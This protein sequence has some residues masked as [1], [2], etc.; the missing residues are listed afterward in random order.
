MGCPPRPCL[1]I[2]EPTEIQIVP[3]IYFAFGSDQ[4]RPESAPILDDIARAL[5][6]HPELRVEII[7][8]RDETEAPALALARAEVVREAFEKRGIDASR[9]TTTGVAG[10]KD[11]RFVEFEVIQP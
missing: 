1:S 7:G 8:R 9:L 3:K 2:V 5:A 6:Q 10:T 11:S 4:L